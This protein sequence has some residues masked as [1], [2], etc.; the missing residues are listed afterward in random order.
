MRSQTVKE[1]L[2]KKRWSWIQIAT[3]GRWR[4]DYLANILLGAQL[5]RA[6]TTLHGTENRRWRSVGIRA[7]LL[8]LASHEAKEILSWECRLNRGWV[9]GSTEKWRHSPP[10]VAGIARIRRDRRFP[11]QVFLLPESSVLVSGSLDPWQ[12][13][14]RIPRSSVP[15]LQHPHL[16]LDSPAFVV[17]PGCWWQEPRF[18]GVDRH[19]FFQCRSESG[20]VQIE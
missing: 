7:N 14:L 2:D 6:E 1:V 9:R 19:E 13:V 8:N 5:K 20:V 12:P 17:E 15:T 4:L 11:E 10:K 3:F 18:D 16:A